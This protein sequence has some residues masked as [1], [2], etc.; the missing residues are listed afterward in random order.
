LTSITVLKRPRCRLG[1]PAHGG[2]AAAAARDPRL[3]TDWEGVDGK[4]ACGKGRRGTPVPIAPCTSRCRAQGGVIWGCCWAGGWPT[5]VCMCVCVC[6]CVSVCVCDV[7]ACHPTH[8]GVLQC[9][10]VEEVGIRTWLWANI[11]CRMHAT[12]QQH[13]SPSLSLSA[14]SR[15]STSITQRVSGFT[16]DPNCLDGSYFM[17]AVFLTKQVAWRTY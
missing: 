2:V 5:S 1:T 8:L 17:A 13:A 10:C 16:L 11:S 6:V 15:Q 12:V 14:L 4:T 3:P 9:V 7:P